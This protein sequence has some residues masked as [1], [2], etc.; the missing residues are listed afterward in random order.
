MVKYNITKIE[1]KTRIE[2]LKISI[3]RYR[4]SR[5]V[6]NKELIS[7]EAEDAL[8][9]E[10]FD[11]EEQFSEFITPDSPTQ[12]VGG[13]PLKQF[14]KVRHSSRMLSFN[15]AFSQAD[16][17]DWQG[18]NLKLLPLSTKLDFYAELKLDGLAIS[19]VYKYGVLKTGATRGDGL[20]GEDVTNNLKTVEA[21][22][23]RLLS[24]SEILKNLEQAKLSHV[25]TRLKKAWP[26]I[27]EA[28]GETFLNR[29][30]FEALNREQKKRGL[31][32]YANPRNVAAGSIRQ[33]DPKITASRRLDSFA[34]SLITDL[35]Q[36]THEEEHLILHS[37][38][39]R[40]NPNNKRF[41]DF[42][43]VFKFHKY[44][45][46]HREKLPFEIDGIV[47][48]VNSE[49]HVRRLG[50]VGKAPRGGIAYKFAP[51]ESETVVENIIAQIGRTGILTPVAVLRPVQIGGVTVSRATLHN[52]DEIKRLGLK[53][54]DTVIV[55][56]AGDV[57]PD[58]RKVLKELRTGREK[59]F[60]FP[61][62]FC[63]QKVVRVAG[64]AAYKILHP[65]KCELVNR[66]RLYH[67]AA[68]NAF[69]MEGI[70]PKIIGAMMDNN[71]ISDAA[72]LFDLKTGDLVPLERFAEKS[73]ENV[74]ES[75][76]KSKT[77]PLNKFINALGIPHVGEETAVDIGKKL[78]LAK[79]INHPRDI[80][81]AVSAM[82]LEDWRSI[83]N[84]G[85]TV[86]ESIHGY[87]QDKNNLAF[88]RKLDKVG[89]KIVSPKA[90]PT[91][92]NFKGKI[93]VLTGGL[94][95]MTRDQAKDKIRERGGDVSSSVGKIID[96]V[97]AGS[98]PGEK[99][100]RAKRLGIKIIDEKQFI[101]MIR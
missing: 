24:Y 87:F 8:K 74:I 95:T 38:G 37:L 10:L 23:L 66:K 68:K 52:E 88:L 100:E 14:P 65:E 92:Q 45:A 97:V 15:D 34:Y 47:V 25:I 17:K 82:K 7:P 1:A 83:P 71:L 18:R 56:R 46:G 41:S 2:K 51:K 35:G 53:I 72:D 54:G 50:V 22:P 49:E 27:I 84:I 36:R 6:L 59:E 29:K 85:P 73:A 19:T 60:H 77:V 43:G 3:N 44:W 79:S 48:M 94:E 55:G 13:K 91:P 30:D 69:D 81:D 80:V 16:M 32:L 42:E 96:Y 21:I 61:K 31:P 28:R 12:R 67:F 4:Y 78:V 26:K 99:Y 62:E 70:G 33:L 89:V 39:F 11:L 93:F 86:A 9:K 98:E 76:Q 57:I 40:V 90:S 75:I 58:V 101:K 64:E 5:L 20:V 63:G